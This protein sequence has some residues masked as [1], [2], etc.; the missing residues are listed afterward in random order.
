MPKKQKK[1]FETCKKNGHQWVRFV[2][3]VKVIEPDHQGFGGRTEE[4]YAFQCERCGKVDE[5][6][7]SYNCFLT[8]AC[9][10]ARQLPDDCVELETLRRFRDTY[11]VSLPSG[12]GDLREYYT[13]APKLVTA[14]RDDLNPLFHFGKIY[15][16]VVSPCVRLIEE[17]RLSEAY[18]LYKISFAELCEQ[19]EIVQ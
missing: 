15:D 9:V 19:F 13:I 6:T 5:G 16:T 14:I 11:V 10:E 17:G 12:N 3:F 2:K 7:P 4:D 8:S 1:S 18:L